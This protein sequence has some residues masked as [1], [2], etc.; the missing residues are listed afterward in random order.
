MICMRIANAL[1]NSKITLFGSALSLF[2]NILLNLLFLK[3]FGVIGISLATLVAYSFMALFW[4]LVA[5][6][7]ITRAEAVKVF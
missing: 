7:L 5:N 3:H 2:L 4:L 1:E 6:R